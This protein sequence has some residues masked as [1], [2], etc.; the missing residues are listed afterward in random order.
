MVPEEQGEKREKPVRDLAER[1]KFRNHKNLL[2]GEAR[3]PKLTSNPQQCFFN[4]ILRTK[5]ASDG[6]SMLQLAKWEAKG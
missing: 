4:A 2:F 3:N 1:G 6:G 5:P